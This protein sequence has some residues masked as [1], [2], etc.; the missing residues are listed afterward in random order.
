M[1]NG[2]A[3]DCFKWFVPAIAGVMDSP[4]DHFLTGTTFA[5][6]AD[7]EIVVLD[8][9]DD[10]KQ[11]PKLRIRPDNA[12]EHRH[13]SECFNGRFRLFIQ[14]ACSVLAQPPEFPEEISP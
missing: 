12:V 11:L 1:G 10:L 9:V 7:I 13:L 6:D 4:G 8:L 14:L 3:I 5:N 2:T